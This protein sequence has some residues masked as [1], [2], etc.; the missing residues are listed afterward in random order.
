M[1]VLPLLLALS[2]PL[3]VSAQTPETE[4]QP[5]GLLIPTES[6]STPPSAALTQLLDEVRAARLGPHPFADWEAMPDLPT[7][8]RDNDTYEVATLPAR[9]LLAHDFR[10][11]VFLRADGEVWVVRDGGLD[12]HREIYRRLSPPNRS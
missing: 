10:T 2:L 3:L 4:A 8:L 1:R 9:P 11:A 7:W 6:D 5:V 12:G